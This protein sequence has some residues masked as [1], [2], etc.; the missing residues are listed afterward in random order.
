MYEFIQEVEYFVGIGA[1]DRLHFDPL[2]ELVDGHQYSV[3]SSWRSRERPNHVEPLASEGPGWWYGD[4]LVGRDMLLLGEVLA[5]MAP[6][7]E[8]FDIA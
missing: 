7:D 2:G 1:C 3:E 5:P 4:Y 8:F 6:S